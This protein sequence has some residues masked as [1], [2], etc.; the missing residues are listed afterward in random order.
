MRRY[1]IEIENVRI[2]I[3]SHVWFREEICRSSLLMLPM[4]LPLS[5][6]MSTSYGIVNKIHS[7]SSKSF[8]FVFLLLL[9]KFVESSLVLPF[10]VVQ[11]LFNVFLFNVEHNKWHACPTLVIRSFILNTLKWISNVPKMRRN[12]STSAYWKRARGRETG[13]HFD[14]SKNWRSHHVL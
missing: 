3:Y 2:D 1:Y 8:S 10:T 14:P 4:P 11:T 12:K 5:S 6:S 7:W 13:L 9:E